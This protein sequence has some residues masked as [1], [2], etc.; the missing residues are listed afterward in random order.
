ME[1]PA[2][3]THTTFPARIGLIAG[4]GDFPL[5]IARAAASAGTEV[6]ALCISGFA[7][8]KLPELSTR[9]HWL[10]LGQ[11]GKAME[12]LKEEQVTQLIMAGRV[13]HNSIFQYKHFDWRAMK[14]MAKAAGK[15]A[16]ALLATVCDEFA[17]EGIEVVESSMFLR[18]LMPKAGLLTLNRS[19]TDQE[20]ADIEFGTPIAKLIA[21]QDIGQ[22]IVVKDKMVVAVEG[23][24]GTDKC[25]R[26]AGELAG[27]GCV[28][29]KVSKPAQDLRFDIPVIGPG[30][31]QSM[32][33]AGASALA[34]SS[35]RSL[36]FHRDEV[37]A[38]AEKN[39]IGI[40][41]FEDTDSPNP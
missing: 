40:L 8:E 38:E 2:L 33:E 21:G 35:R 7:S 28:V 36:L 14:L 19:L 5:L 11:L 39:N 34:L 25:I 10:E 30:T 23:I 12:L 3:H 24:E 22:T 16:D 26:R 32:K 31:V 9:H 17:K 13:P 15:R 6:I 20:N 37:I 4:Q 41:V 1:K 27:A 29:I 18:S